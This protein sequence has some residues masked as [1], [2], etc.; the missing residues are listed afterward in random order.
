M[1]F[2][3]D[4][5]YQENPHG[6]GE[7]FPEVVEFFA[8]Y[9]KKTARVLDVGCGQGRDALPIARLG[10]TVVG[11]DLSRAGIEQMLADA[12]QE[13][14]DVEGILADITDYKPDGTFD[15]ILIDRTLHMLPE[16]SERLRVLDTLTDHAKDEVHILIA[17]E[18][19]NLPAMKA[20]L[21]EKGWSI[22]M[23]K[24]GFL[25]GKRV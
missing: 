14:L 15:V 5:F 18:K 10:H 3:Y 7:P 6:L 4:Q 23:E 16:E 17:D 25:F 9:E 19:Q 8:G 21:E 13:N 20:L 2:Q 1:T 11:V 24:K 12:K 22:T